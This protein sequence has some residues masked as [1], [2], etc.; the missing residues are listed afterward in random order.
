MN[1]I[2]DGQ[3][4]P[5]DSLIHRLQPKVKIILLIFI[6]VA[7]IMTDTMLGYTILTAMVAVTIFLSQ[8]NFRYAIR[9]IKR[10]SYLFLFVLIMNTLF[11]E[12]GT[13]LF[14]YGIIKISAGGIAQGINIVLRVIFLMVIS[15]MLMITTSPKEI[16]NGL[17]EIMSPLEIVRFPVHDTAMIISVAMQFIPTFFE[18]A[19]RIK[20]A[21][22]ARGAEFEGKRLTGRAANMIPL[23]VPLIFCAFKRADE[24]SMAMEARGYRGGEG[25]TRKEKRPL[26]NSDVDCFIITTVICLVLV[27]IP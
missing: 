19:D 18:E 20:M 27:L 23:A 14:S 21:Q 9:G 22:M 15:S 3:Y 1:S 10:L 2:M 6:I 4:M 16:T 5:V 24:L 25:R 11:F 13:M 8:T 17:E 26:R 12:S 7:V